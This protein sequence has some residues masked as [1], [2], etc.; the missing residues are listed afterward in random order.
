MIEGDSKDRD[1]LLL[2][3]KYDFSTHKTRDIE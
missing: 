2:Y 1:L 3:N